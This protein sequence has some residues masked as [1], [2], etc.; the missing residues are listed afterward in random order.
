MAYRIGADSKTAS[1]PLLRKASCCW[2]GEKLYS[3]AQWPMSASDVAAMFGEVY[4]V[5]FAQLRRSWETFVMT[6]EYRPG[7]QA[8]DTSVWSP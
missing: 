1:G 4:G 5:S 6:Y 3:S 8:R 7:E 2:L